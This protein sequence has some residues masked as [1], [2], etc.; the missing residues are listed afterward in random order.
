MRGHSYGDQVKHGI[1]TWFGNLLG[2]SIR[3]MRGHSYGDQVKLGI[4]PTD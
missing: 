2:E 4:I 1:I 3:N